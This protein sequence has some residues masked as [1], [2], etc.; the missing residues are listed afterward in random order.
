[1]EIQGHIMKA[2]L[3]AEPFLAFV[4]FG[5]LEAEPG[6]PGPGADTLL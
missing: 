6:Q 3:T 2:L 1:M 4:L 5:S